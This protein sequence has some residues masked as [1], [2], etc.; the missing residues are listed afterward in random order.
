MVSRPSVSL[1]SLI[2]T[3]SPCS[4]PSGSAFITACSA[5]F[6]SSRARS[7]PLPVTALTAGLMA[8]TWSMHESRSSTG[9]SCF[10]PIRCRA[11]TAERSQGF[12]IR[13]SVRHMSELFLLSSTKPRNEE[14]Q[15]T[16]IRVFW[17]PH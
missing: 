3:G 14:A 6:A 15:V 5:R 13:G 2:P 1:R 16:P 4:K 9:E 17:Q 11:S 8:S 12:D 10:A 7:Y